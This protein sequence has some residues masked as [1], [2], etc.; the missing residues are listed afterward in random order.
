MS[1]NIAGEIYNGCIAIKYVRSEKGK[2]IWLWKC[3]GN[4]PGCLG[5][6]EAKANNVKN[7]SYT[8][9]GCLRIENIA[10]EIYNGC[11]AIKY[12]RTS[13]NGA[14]WLF[15]CEYN[16]PGCKGT[17]ETLAKSVKRGSTKSCGCLLRTAH[18][19]SGTPED[20]AYD[21]MVSRCYDVN[22]KDYKDYGGRG[23]GVCDRW[24]DPVY[25]RANFHMDMG[26]KPNSDD[27]LDRIDNDGD[28]SLDNT[29]WATWKDQNRNKRNNIVRSIEEVEHIRDVYFNHNWSV[30]NIAE[31][32]RC[33]IY[34]IYNII[35]YKTWSVF[36]VEESKFIRDVHKNHNWLVKNIAEFF[37]CSKLTIINII[38]NK[39]RSLI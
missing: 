31:F 34:A 14:V 13:S 28:Y 1:K 23:I 12:V 22:D 7:G 36:T 26:K 2:A 20:L 18:G 38:N 16:G 10:G 19:M 15:K 24:R 27:S 9:C 35:N 8:S 25:G 11:I 29:R 6:F 37:R 30:K 21:N 5:T 17:F 33:T 39:N 32:F 4:G 3:P